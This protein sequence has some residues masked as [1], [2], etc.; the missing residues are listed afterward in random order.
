MH[1]FFFGFLVVLDAEWCGVAIVWNFCGEV[2]DGVL[3]GGVEVLEGDRRGGGV[4]EV[5]E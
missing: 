1:W 4:T 5:V 2:R 3:G